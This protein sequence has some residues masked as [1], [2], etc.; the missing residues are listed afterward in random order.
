[1]PL[2]PGDRDKILRKSGAGNPLGAFD[3]KSCRAVAA[4]RLAGDDEIVSKPSGIARL[5]VEYQLSGGHD[6]GRMLHEFC[7]AHFARTIATDKI[8][9]TA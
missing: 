2:R 6:A 4:R 5:P 1:M 7:N 3:G 8:D 9:V